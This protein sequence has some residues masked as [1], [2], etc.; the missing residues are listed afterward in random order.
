MAGAALWIVDYVLQAA[1]NGVDRLYFHQGTIGN[2]VSVFPLNLS[3][4]V[5]LLP[6]HWIRHH[7][8]LGTEVYYILQAYCFWG[9]SSVFAP[10]YGAALVSEF[11]GPDRTKLV[12]LDDGTSA[13]AAYAVYTT[14]NVP[15]R[16]L[17]INSDYYDGSST[18]PRSMVS[19]TG[20]RQTTSTRPLSVAAVRRM[21]APSA[22]AL[23]NVTIAGG[24]SFTS[25]CARTGSTTLESVRV[26]NGS[27]SVSVQASEALIVLL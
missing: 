12:M 2:C 19:F 24:E 6:R 17:V 26:A 11:L 18:R 10:Y 13:L 22:T 8:F 1:L 27:L 15:V 21:T 9:N 25:S 4:S 14:A 3:Y 23:T 16:L 5:V 20:L 7:S